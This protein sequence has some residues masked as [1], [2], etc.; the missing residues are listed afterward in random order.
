MVVF[1]SL[2][3]HF[4]SRISIYFSDI[5][6]LWVLFVFLYLVSFWFGGHFFSFFQAWHSSLVVTSS[7]SPRTAINVCHSLVRSTYAT[8]GVGR[9][10]CYIL[11]S[12][13]SSILELESGIS[14]EGVRWGVL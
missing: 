9:A 7:V 6:F 11:L 12:V 5:L 13:K 8:P 10:G 3:P 2:S 4:I 14:E 1:K